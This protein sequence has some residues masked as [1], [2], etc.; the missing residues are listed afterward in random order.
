M[1]RTWDVIA[2]LG[3]WLLITD[4]ENMD[5]DFIWEEVSKIL[6]LALLPDPSVTGLIKKLQVAT[7]EIR[8]TS[9]RS[10]LKAHKDPLILLSVHVTIWLLPEGKMW[11]PQMDHPCL[12]LYPYFISS[13]DEQSV[14]FLFF[15]FPNTSFFPTIQHGDPVKHTCI[16]YFFFTLSCSIIMT[17]QSSQCYTAGSHC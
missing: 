8:P 13:G 11:L 5:W 4:W 17:R 2:T 7:H 14:I 1:E 6:C 3:D 9:N 12:L 16:H 10:P 15:N